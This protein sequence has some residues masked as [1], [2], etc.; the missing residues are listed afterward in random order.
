MTIIEQACRAPITTIV[1]NAGAEGAEIVSELKKEAD[2][3]IGYNAQTGEYVKTVLR[4][5]SFCSTVR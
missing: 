1:K 4:Q 3:E 2:A 5:I